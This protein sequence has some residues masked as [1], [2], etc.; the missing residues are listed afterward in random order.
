[1]TI[2]D[3]LESSV[4]Y[5]GNR[6]RT[7]EGILQAALCRGLQLGFRTE[8]ASSVQGFVPMNS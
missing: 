5:P 3:S 2:S 7:W 4:H 1:M 8:D 6:C